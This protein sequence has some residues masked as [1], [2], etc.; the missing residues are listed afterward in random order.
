MNA[1]VEIRK[2]LE[3]VVVDNT[4]GEDGPKIQA[5][6]DARRFGG[7]AMVLVSEHNGGYGYGNNLAVREALRAP[8]PPELSQ[9]LPEGGQALG[10]LHPLLRRAQA[11]GRAH[12]AQTRSP[13]PEHG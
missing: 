7:W 3:G 1:V 13:A 8:Q 10:G 4:C 5:A 9:R 6:I 2:G 12:P 11:P